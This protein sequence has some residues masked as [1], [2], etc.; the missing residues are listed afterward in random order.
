MLTTFDPGSYGGPA[1]GAS[2]CDCITN[3][4]HAFLVTVTFGQE[5]ALKCR[6]A[7]WYFGFWG[8]G[9]HGLLSRCSRSDAVTLA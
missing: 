2:P 3:A 4:R 7:S 5:G 1:Y 8:V 6:N 9:C